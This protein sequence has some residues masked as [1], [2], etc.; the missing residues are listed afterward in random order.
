MEDLLTANQRSAHARFFLG[1][2][3]KRKESESRC[4][5]TEPLFRLVL[6]LEA[7]GTLAEDARH[8]VEKVQT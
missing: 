6:I 2:G 5:W 4:Q 3:A 8:L 7:D 1:I